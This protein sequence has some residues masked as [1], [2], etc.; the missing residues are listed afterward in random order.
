MKNPNIIAPHY[1]VMQIRVRKGRRWI[2]YARF[3]SLKK[4]DFTELPASLNV[5]RF[6][7]VYMFMTATHN[8]VLNAIIASFCKKKNTCIEALI[9]TAACIGLDIQ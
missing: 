9:C 3:L 1:L 4:K 8:D 5:R 2:I 6:T 7:L